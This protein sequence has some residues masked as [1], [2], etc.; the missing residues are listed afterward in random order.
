[1]EGGGITFLNNDEKR[2]H[3]VLDNRRL[4]SLLLDDNASHAIASRIGLLVLGYNTSK[5]RSNVPFNEGAVFGLEFG[6]LILLM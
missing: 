4:I 1:M 5:S 6:L 2:S 3:E